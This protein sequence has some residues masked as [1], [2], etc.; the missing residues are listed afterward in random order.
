MGYRRRPRR[1]APCSCAASTPAAAR[2]W[3]GPYAS[4]CA[5]SCP[6]CSR[7][8]DGRLLVASDGRDLRDR[9]GDAARRPPLSGRRATAPASAPTAP[10]SRSA[11]TDGR[12]RLLDLAS[13]RVRTPDAG[14]T[15][16]AVEIGA[17]SPDGRTLATGGEDGSV[18]VWDVQ[19]GTARSRP[20]RA[21]AAGCG[22][23][24]SAPT[25]A[26]STRPSDDSTA[27]IW[28][29]AGDRR[30]GRAVPHRSSAS[31]GDDTRRRLPARLRPQPRR[32]HARGRA[33]STAGS[34]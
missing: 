17:F 29:V 7:A 32:A 12:V 27:I 28:D 20:S 24:P 4:P 19:R 11:A 13:G 22:A 18:I 16:R 10:R 31:S 30:L 21:T 15:T 2:R 23:R 33:G 1:T 25:G 5:R 9:R 3:D 34:T 26:P 14:A 8:P 6:G